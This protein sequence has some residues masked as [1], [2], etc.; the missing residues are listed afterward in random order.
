MATA[1]GGVEQHLAPGVLAQAARDRFAHLLVVGRGRGRGSGSRCHAVTGRSQLGS[2]F[3][4]YR[5]SDAG[6]WA[7]RL[8]DS[9]HRALPRADIFMDVDK[10]PPGVPFAEYIA[11]EVGNCQALLV[12]I[13]PHWST[14]ESLRRL[15]EDDDFVRL[16]IAAAMKRDIR[17]IPTRVG[18]APLPEKAQL[19]EEIRKLL[20]RQDFVISDRSW[21]DDCKRLALHLKALLGRDE[22]DDRRRWLGIA[23]AAVGVG[24]ATAAGSYAW[25]RQLGRA[26]APTVVSALPT[27]APTAAPTPAPAPTRAPAPAPTPVAPP[28]RA[29]APPPKPAAPPVVAAMPLVPVAALS[30]RLEGTW[31]PVESTKFRQGEGFAVVRGK[32]SSLR[33][34][35]VAAGSSSAGQGQELGTAR[36]ND[37]GVVFDGP[38]G[39]R[40][41]LS[42]GTRDASWTAV[43]ATA[44]K[45]GLDG[46]PT[47]A[48]VATGSVDVSAGL[49]R[50]SVL[51]TTSDIPQ[52]TMLL[53][54]TLAD[55]DSR[56]SLRLKESQRPSAETYVFVR[57]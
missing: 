22:S 51:L 31:R 40:I 52:K 50:W 49:R 2:I 28:D 48:T 8:V 38:G 25:W 12:L 16:E 17:V 53:E 34:S 30:L 1:R 24:A 33:L 41:E 6:G 19:P 27:P 47:Y 46:Q 18:D 54:G 56:L 39:V 35:V 43:M 11:R 37:Q 42:P 57:N 15:A 32:W 5:R 9:L 29:P 10:I 55:D 20:D 4:S 44:R 45:K 26:P 7:G 14:P 36:P 21:D 3:L 13:G 23:S